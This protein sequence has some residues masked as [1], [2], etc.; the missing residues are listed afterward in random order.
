MTNKKK[1]IIAAL[2]TI[3]FGTL[4]VSLYLYTKLSDVFVTPNHPE[5]LPL[6]SRVF[7]TAENTHRPVNILLLGYGGEGHDGTYL[8]DVMIVL[9]LER[10]SKKALITSIPRDLWVEI[11]TD[12]N[13]NQKSK[14]NTAFAF[15]NAKSRAEGGNLA[16]L[17]TSQAIGMPID[18]YVAVDFQGFVDVIDSLG[19]IDVNVPETFDDYY[20]PIKGLENETCGF[21]E[22]TISQLHVDFS[23]FDLE[24]RFVCRW[25]HLHFD[26][27]IV[28]MDGSTAL[29]FVRSR[30]SD[31]HGGDFSRS[32]RQFEVLEAI[33][34]KIVSL[35]ALPQVDRIIE[36]LGESVMTDIDHAVTQEVIKLKLDP[37]SY[38]VK[39]ISLSTDNVLVN[40]T[41]PA[42]QY[43]LI[44]R[45]GSNNFSQI[46][47]FIKSF[48]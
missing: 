4:L 38:S 34:K 30:H 47:A 1:V 20:Y 39:T 42:G 10:E 25:E 33:K 17:V 12:T 21:T 45:A 44:P 40:S 18:Y 37:D 32:V 43:I 19:K 27:G 46:H 2:S 6:K 16:K 22:E 35:A 14:I 15:G 11:P 9:S 48:L 5:L 24:K 23:G 13:E 28:S 41:G 8:T 31:T 29:K 36:E 7:E 26:K 3:L